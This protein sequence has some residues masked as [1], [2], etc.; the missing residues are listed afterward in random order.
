M[1]IWLRKTQ[2]FYQKSFANNFQN[3]A[4]KHTLTPIII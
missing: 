3:E 4:E 2:L 1:E